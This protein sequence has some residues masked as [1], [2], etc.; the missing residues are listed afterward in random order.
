MP[1][2]DLRHLPNEIPGEHVVY[3]LRRHVITITSL[4]VS[5]VFILTAPLAV[6]WYLA[7]NV[8]T[9]SDDPRLFPLVVLGISLF[10]LFVWLFLFQALMD[11]YL[12]IWVVTTKRILSIEQT[13]LF[14]RRVS[15]LRLYRIQDVTATVSGFLH[16]VFNYGNVE[17]QTAGE[18]ERFIFEDVPSPNEVAKTILQLV[19]EDRKEH[20]DEALEEMDAKKD[21]HSRGRHTTPPV[22]EE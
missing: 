11:Y 17:I 13:G 8:P 4:F 14:N 20:F 6:L 18:K 12:D 9:I 16:T 5:Y 7:T 21:S 15:E 19:E 2:L 1:M 3:F 22:A 10:F